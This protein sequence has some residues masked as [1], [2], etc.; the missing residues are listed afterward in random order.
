MVRKQNRFIW[1]ASRELAP[2]IPLQAYFVQGERYSVWVD[3]GDTLMVEDIRETMDRAGIPAEALRFIVNTHSHP[4]QIGNN[5]WLA[6]LTD[7]LVAAHRQYAHWH[8]DFEKLYQEY[9]RSLL[10]EV[11]TDS[12]AIR[13]E[14]LNIL[15]V[16]HAVDLFVDEGSQF[17]LGGPELKA[18]R[19]SGHL[20]AQLGW[21]EQKTRNFIIGDVITRIDAPR[22]HG[23]VSVRGYREALDKL[24]KLLDSLEVEWVL[25]AHYE[26]LSREE[27]KALILKVRE[28][29]DR[30]QTIVLNLITGYELINLE[31]LWR[32]VCKTIEKEPDFRALRTVYAHVQELKAAGKVK[33]EEELIYAPTAK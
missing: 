8:D 10:P 28:F 1:S 27:T 9:A 16:P 26:P 22:F 33:E 20:T 19:F 11:I 31:D 5:G 24:E 29:L 7:A 15:G 18:Y 3:S 30:L 32:E 17:N 6:E 13:D 14:V 25:P 21:F 23:H 2:G 4:G 12:A